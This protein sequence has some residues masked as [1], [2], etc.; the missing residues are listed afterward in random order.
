[1][2]WKTSW[3]SGLNT[4]Q[5]GLRMKLVKPSGERAGAVASE[6]VM[7]CPTGAAEV[8]GSEGG[9]RPPTGRLCRDTGQCEVGFR[10]NSVK[11]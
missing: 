1:M 3:C 11:N 4:S 6:T 7:Q 9:S 10:P 2:S 5:A 8:R